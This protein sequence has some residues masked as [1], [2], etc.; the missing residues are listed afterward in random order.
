M[1]FEYWENWIIYSWMSNITSQ[2]FGSFLI[3]IRAILFSGCTTFIRTSSTKIHLCILLL[4]SSTAI[5]V[6]CSEPCNGCREDSSLTARNSSLPYHITP[7]LLP[8]EKASFFVK[9]MNISL[10]SEKIVSYDHEKLW[11]ALQWPFVQIWRRHF[12]ATMLKTLHRTTLHYLFHHPS[13]FLSVAFVIRLDSLN[14]FNVAKKT[15]SQTHLKFKL[16][17]SSQHQNK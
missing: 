17:L 8:K 16:M 3:Y 5:S 9:K 11:T 2:K 10:H 15:R 7:Y 6:C 12:L 13:C 1:K 4:S 14:F